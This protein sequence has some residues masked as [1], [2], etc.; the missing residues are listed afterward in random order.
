MT[1]DELLAT[2]A[3]SSPDDWNTI[4]CWGARSGPSFLDQFV[5]GQTRTD[6]GKMEF[7]L[8]RREH[9]NRAAYKPDLSINV[10]FGLN[11]D[12]LFPDEEPKLAPLD[13]ADFADPDWSF[14]YCDFFYCGNLVQRVPYA[15]VDGGRSIL[16]LPDNEGYVTQ[17]QHD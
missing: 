6:D 15:V 17:W 12:Q 3:Q 14:Q 5:P 2:C 10:G 1:L 11:P 8:H 9:S 4:T 13:F 16:P 7:R